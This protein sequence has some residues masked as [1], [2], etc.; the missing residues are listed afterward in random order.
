MLPRFTSRI[1]P[2]IAWAGMACCWI[3]SPALADPCGP[4]DLNGDGQVD[5]ADYLEFLN[6]YDA[7][8]PAVDFTGDG[9]VD[10]ADYLEF[11][12]LYEAG[13]SVAII[14]GELASNPLP[15]YPFAE[16]VNAF[17]TGAAVTISVD[18]FRHPA[19]VGA[20][21]RVYITADKSAA[22]W[23][24]DPSLVDVR[25]AFQLVSWV[26]GS[27]DLNR[28][29]LSGSSTLPA[30]SGE[31]LGI[32]YDLV[33][34]ANSN[35]VLD[36]GDIIDGREAP[37]FWKVRDLSVANPG[38]AVT[39][40]NTVSV[41]VG[42]VAAGFEDER[43]YYPSDIATRG[44]IPLVVIGHGNG[45]NYTW[46]DYVGQHLASYG[47][48]VISHENN[49]G[50]GSVT[51][52]T[53]QLDHTNTI[54]ALQSTLA[55]GVL[56]G[57]I[58]ANRLY[59]IGH[60]RGGDG[61]ATGYDRLFDGAYTPTG[62]FARVFGTSNFKL[63][64]AISPTDFQGTTGTN[65]H[66]AN[67]HLLYGHAD[68][69]VRGSV[70]SGSKPFAVFERAERNRVSTLLQGVGHNEFN[71]CGFA[72]ATGPALIGRA[73]AQT[74]AKVYFLSAAAYYV[75][76]DPTG[77][78][79]LWRQYESFRAPSTLGTAVV[80]LDLKDS[81]NPVIDDFQTQTSTGT[82]SSGGTV[83][84]SVT[85]LSEAVMRDLDSSFTWATTDPMSGMSRALSTDTTR[86]AVFDWSL[87]D[88]FMEFQVVPSL[89]DFS[90]SKYLSF[91]ACQGSR[92]PE[93]VAELG[94]VT[95]VVTLRDG[96]GNTSSISIG[97]YGGGVEEPY[98]RT[99]DGTGAG[100]GNEFET[101]RIRTADFGTNG[102]GLDLTD[103]VAVRFEFGPAF[104]SSRGRVAL[105][106]VYL[107][108]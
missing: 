77:K 92:H 60:S 35:G 47:Y 13:C 31:S 49:T 10:F 56:N 107:A 43:W 20:S 62:G 3:A 82:S 5:F 105:D 88:R 69:D 38:T 58:D 96:S 32:G 67:F 86:G 101:I 64:T 33:I 15:V 104:G 84:S 2:V 48:I 25:G 106:D 99:G 102:T 55:G 4:A 46:Y 21:T 70:A 87:A 95:F 23:S 17:N 50:P 30:I 14:D 42:R 80:A 76:G 78:E 8:D 75:N 18:P 54:I 28:I 41:P 97:A 81:G 85:N 94:D 79:Y 16:F 91:R 22:Q 98:Q 9:L 89:K 19:L 65:P 1:G 100:W 72:D 51:A 53:T 37:G 27:I 11:L 103:I 61:V 36:G 71:C 90:A 63:I 24:S 26:G 12:N 39:Q 59:W 29:A 83:T 93:T 34:D 45:H 57:H 68:G 52:A 66:D 40:I 6:L 73:A 74:I 108:N 44:Q 7:Q